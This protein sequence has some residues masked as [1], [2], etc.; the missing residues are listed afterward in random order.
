M[1]E[2]LHK[3]VYYKTQVNFC[4]AN[5]KILST[6]KIYKFATH[7]LD[8][9]EG[10]MKWG[11]GYIGGYHPNQKYPCFEMSIID[12]VATL[13]SIEQ[14]NHPFRHNGNRDCP[15][16][17]EEVAKDMVKLAYEIA[18]RKGC[19]C[20]KFTDT[21]YV[22][23]PNKISLSD[24]SLITTGKAW[25][26]SILPFEPVDMP[27][28]KQS[29]ARFKTITWGEAKAE[30]QRDNRIMPFIDVSDETLAIEVFKAMWES[31]KYCDFFS[32]YTF[33]LAFACGGISVWGDWVIQIPENGK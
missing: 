5:P 33:N 23:C 28:Y 20:L 6:K 10:V 14:G 19:I 12:N 31:H 2:T 1:T 21:F 32:E 8:I 17:S 16:G 25:V 22:N 3:P 26:E 4:R 9:E 7:T 13:Q 18:K 27:K 29:I 15:H 11:D 30:F 24:L